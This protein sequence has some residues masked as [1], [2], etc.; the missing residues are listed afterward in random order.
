MRF[1]HLLSDIVMNPEE[2]ASEKDYFR[3]LKLHNNPVIRKFK[4]DYWPQM[5]DQIKYDANKKHEEEDLPRD[6]DRISTNR[7]QEQEEIPLGEQGPIAAGFQ[8][9]TQGVA[10][11]AAGAVAGAKQLGQNLAGAVTGSQQAPQNPIA[12]GQQ[13]FTNQQVNQMADNVVQ[14]LGLPPEAKMAVIN[15]LSKLGMDLK[16]QYAMQDARNARLQQVIN[17]F[18]T[19]Y[20][21]NKTGQ[22][23]TS[24]ITQ[25][26]YVN[27]TTGQVMPG[28]VFGNQLPAPYGYQMVSRRPQS[29]VAPR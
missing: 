15:S 24:Q 11:Y 28:K 2:A 9:M 27:K 1:S 16:Q 6:A 3:I 12:V 13:A 22:Q 17:N 5:A 18:N 14:M 29:P 19:E 26:P 21:L 23:L 4:E 20:A 10:P 7:E 8:G 25:N